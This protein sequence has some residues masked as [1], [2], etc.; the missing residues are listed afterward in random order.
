MLTDDHI[1]ALFEQ[2][3]PVNSGHVENKVG[4]G[5]ARAILRSNHTARAKHAIGTVGALLQWHDKPV[6]PFKMFAALPFLLL[7][8]KCLFY[9]SVP[10][11]THYRCSRGATRNVYRDCLEGAA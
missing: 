10:F 3:V 6:I 8:Q 5:H 2:C 7:L 4:I 11:E 1:R 9:S